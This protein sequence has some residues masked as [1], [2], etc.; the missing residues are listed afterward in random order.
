MATWDDFDV[1]PPTAPSNTIPDSDPAAQAPSRRTADVH[2]QVTPAA[3]VDDDSIIF[4]DGEQYNDDV[5][6]DYK[7]APDN[8]FDLPDPT[9]LLNLP[10]A[11]Q[12]EQRRPLGRVDLTD[13]PDETD[14]AAGAGADKRKARIAARESANEAKRARRESDREARR[15]AQAERKAVKAEQHADEPSER[16]SRAPRQRI[17]LA[18]A[19]AVVVVA[20]G[21]WGV[22]FL[23]GGTEDSP[24]SPPVA[25]S[26]PTAAARTASTPVVPAGPPDVESLGANCPDDETGSVTTGRGEGGVVGGPD[27]IKRF[28]HGYYVDRKGATAREVVRP[29]AAVGSG[30]Q[31]DASIARLPDPTQYCLQITDRGQGLWAVQ[32]IE[33][34][35]VQRTVYPQLVQTTEQDGRTWITSIQADKDAD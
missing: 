16:E 30:P 34:T 14:Q 19:L 21:I 3:A 1:D 12:R 18:G 5:F 2:R 6:A 7:S 9:S 23:R 25:T 10:A 20:A 32:L 35:P 29:D 31:L 27:V 22:S 4:D 24:K 26:S 8:A 15:T 33:V 13:A 28:Q 11:A 17:I